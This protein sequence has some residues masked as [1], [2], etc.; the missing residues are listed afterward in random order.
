M[1]VY[2]LFDNKSSELVIIHFLNTASNKLL[3]LYM[4]SFHSPKVRESAK[5][6]IECAY[7][8][9]FSAEIGKHVQNSPISVT[10]KD[11]KQQVDGSSAGL[12]YA[13]AFAAALKKHDIINTLFPMPE[14]I[15]ATGVVDNHGN[16]TKIKHLKHKILAAIKEDANIM[17]YPSEN[18]E[19]FLYLQESDIELSTAI[20]NSGI[21][22]K[23]VSSLKQAFCVIGIFP[24]TCLKVNPVR[25]NESLFFDIILDNEPLIELTS[26]NLVFKYDVSKLRF[27]KTF[28]T[29]LIESGKHVETA[30]KDNNTNKLN[31]NLIIKNDSIHVSK[32]NTTLFRLSF[33]IIGEPRDITSNVFEFCED[34]CAIND[35]HYKGIGGFVLKNADISLLTAGELPSVPDSPKNHTIP[36]RLLGV[37]SK[38]KLLITFAVIFAITFCIAKFLRPLF[39]NSDYI[40]TQNP[41]ALHAPV[42]ITPIPS[43]SL[44]N[45]NSSLITPPITITDTPKPTE[46]NN[47]LSPTSYEP[48]NSAKISNDTLIPASSSQ[49]S[50]PKPTEHNVY[51]LI[52]TSKPMPLEIKEVTDCNNWRITADENSIVNINN[53][54]DFKA[55]RIDYDIR[56]NSGD[57]ISLITEPEVFKSL[58]GAGYTKLGFRF[59][60]ISQSSIEDTVIIKVHYN[61]IVKSY[62]IGSTEYISKDGIWIEKVI[63]NIDIS[64]ITAIEV[65]IGLRENG[66]DRGSFLIRD[67][68][69]YK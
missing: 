48:V 40:I 68:Y 10:P 62:S 34:E 29:E 20:N 15:A 46:Q 37:N 44:E 54:E 31:L 6:G 67:F 4:Q 18:Y 43:A 36:H 26:F 51:D 55:L 17:L 30:S 47:A 65:F 35:F 56:G 59:K 39:G 12:A 24:H 1:H 14:R 3:E 21:S 32:K 11:F 7:E 38:T 63:E 33:N 60:C 13:I 42:E 69:I 28:E 2:A 25:T 58:S 22:I 52:P 61:S 45:P 53:D 57:C 19:E 27:D 41:Q 66:V 5:T 49:I 8:L 9:I 23:H 16:I 50:T 64:K